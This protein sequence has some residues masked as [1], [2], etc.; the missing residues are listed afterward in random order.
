MKSALASQLL[1]SSFPLPPLPALS[2]LGVLL[3]RSL[4][5]IA[6]SQPGQHQRWRLIQILSTEIL[7]Q[8]TQRPSEACTSGCLVP[9]SNLQKI[10]QRDNFCHFW[11][12]PW[13]WELESL[14]RGRGR[15]SA[16][17]GV[18][19]RRV[20]LGG[21]VSP[22]AGGPRQ[23]RRIHPPKSRRGEEALVQGP[24]L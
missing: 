18:V 22:G 24:G 2:P 4:Y 23:S 3:P 7:S 1:I 20:L 13:P 5:H 14:L 19:V 6:P 12:E 17:G 11:T 8:Q 16:V 21:V 10:N 9:E 15:V